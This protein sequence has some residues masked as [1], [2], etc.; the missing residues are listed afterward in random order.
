MSNKS[1]L[2]KSEICQKCAKC[3]KVYSWLEFS[4][5][6]AWRFMMLENNKIE[7]KEVET[8]TG[9]G[10]MITI[11][12]PCSKLIKNRDGKY[13]CQLYGEPRPGMCE[14]Y[15]DNIAPMFKELEKCP[16]LK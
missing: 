1:S 12:S 7:V 6:F 8:K 13:Y 3:C 2:A 9:V 11:D 14:T 16:L 10:W 15:P 5:D 4:R